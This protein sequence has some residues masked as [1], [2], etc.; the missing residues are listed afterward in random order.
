MS[1]LEFT[2]S[3][4]KSL[5]WPTVVLIIVV[6]LRKPIAEAL[7][8]GLRRVKAGPFELEW[9]EKL[10]DVRQ[11]V[12]ASPDLASSVVGR[13]TE[14]VVPSDEL[15]ALAKTSPAAAVMESFSRLEAELRRLVQPLEPERSERLSAVGLARLARQ[16]G[17]ISPETENAV[18]GLAVLRNLAAHGRATEDVT[19]GRA[20]EFVALVEAVLFALRSRGNAS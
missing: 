17:R 3:V 20:V 7:R 11:E 6:V 1:G 13:L 10:I 16:H 4:I 15:T 19:V 8:R 5:A 14:A 2:A 9:E 12:E 18:E